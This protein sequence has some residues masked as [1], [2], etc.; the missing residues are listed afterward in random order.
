MWNHIYVV[1]TYLLQL[2]R[3]L[4]SLNQFEFLHNRALLYIISQSQTKSDKGDIAFYL[5]NSNLTSLSQASDSLF[6][7]LWLMTTFY[8]YSDWFYKS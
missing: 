8:L 5:Q 3:A 4:H 7:S 6:V 2:H 1:Q